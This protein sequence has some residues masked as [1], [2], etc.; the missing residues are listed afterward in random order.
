MDEN[1]LDKLKRDIKA[2]TFAFKMFLAATLT[3]LIGFAFVPYKLGDGDRWIY[4]SILIAIPL[5]CV[6]LTVAVFR[7]SRG[8][9][10]EG[11]KLKCLHPELGE[12]NNKPYQVFN[13]I[14]CILEVIMGLVLPSVLVFFVL[15]TDPVLLFVWGFLG[16]DTVLAAMEYQVSRTMRSIYDDIRISGGVPSDFR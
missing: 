4:M 16:V 7:L 2:R 5:I 1:A 6:A 10:I 12:R 8:F 9:L 3:F 13:A 15:R 14:Y 11:I